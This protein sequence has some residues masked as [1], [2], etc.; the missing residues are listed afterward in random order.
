MA[1]RSHHREHQITHTQQQTS[2]HARFGWLVGWLVGWLI[3]SL[4]YCCARV[5]ADA[6]WPMRGARV[7]HPLPR[8]PFALARS[9]WAPLEPRLSALPCGSLTLAHIERAQRSSISCAHRLATQSIATMPRLPSHEATGSKRTADGLVPVDHSTPEDDGR[10]V[11]RFRQ[12]CLFP[13]RL[14]ANAAGVPSL[15]RKR[16]Q[17]GWCCRTHTT[18]QHLQAERAAHAEAAQEKPGR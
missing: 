9:R 1:A 4:C 6:R 18:N 12:P 17:V 11:D 14:E 15:W 8:L 3:D 13:A 10:N 16:A 2:L 7:P 5:L